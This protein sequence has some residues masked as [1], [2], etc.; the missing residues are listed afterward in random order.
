M[1]LACKDW[2]VVIVLK[3][4]RLG[5]ARNPSG[6]HNVGFIFKSSIPWVNAISLPVGT[7]IRATN[8]RTGG[9]RPKNRSTSTILVRNC[10]TKTLGCVARCYTIV[11]FKASDR[12]LLGHE[13]RR[14]PPRVFP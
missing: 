6:R 3:S 8:P 10:F 2:L 13:S 11:P 7:R 9:R 5:G 12:I 14:F 4:C 1:V